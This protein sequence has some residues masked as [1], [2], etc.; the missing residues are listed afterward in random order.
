MAA[1]AAPPP[2]RLYVPNQNDAT[3]SVIDLATR[4]VVETVDLRRYGVGPT[5]KPHHIQVEPDGSAWYV[6]LIGAGKVLKLD[7]ENKLLGSASLEVPGLIALH[8]TKDVMF[9][10]RSMSAP[11]PPPRMAIIQRSDMKVIEE[12]DLLFPRPHGIV[13]HPNGERVYV[14]SLG[15]N[16]IASIA[17]D[18]G[19]VKLVTLPG[20]A[21]HSIVQAAVSPDGKWLTVTGE[22]TGVLVV[23]DLTNPAQPKLVHQI[24]VGAGAFEPVFTGD[25]RWV[26]VTTRTANRIAVVDAKSWTLADT[27]SHPSFVFPH[28]ISMSADG[29]YVLAGSEHQQQ[30]HDSDSAHH[31]GPGGHMMGSA[32][33]PGSI[34]IICAATRKVLTVIPAGQNAAGLGTPAPQGPLPGPSPCK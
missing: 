11:N 27:L 6:T 25:N 2:P 5:A 30:Q 9:V 22:L 1:S 14:T 19:D 34:A 13:V 16:Q 8:P 12:I 17:A 4:K 3:V 20:S 31:D 7:R 32:K 18:G 33:G 28:G 10:A 24:R 29:R 15:T 21:S 26:F 23:F